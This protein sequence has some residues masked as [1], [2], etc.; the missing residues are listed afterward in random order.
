MVN[1]LIQKDGNFVV[2]PQHVEITFEKVKF[3]P[4]S[5]LLE[6]E[7]VVVGDA[8]ANID[9]ERVLGDLVGKKEDII[10]DYLQ[11]DPEIETAR[12]IFS[13]F[14]ISTLPEDVTRIDFQIAF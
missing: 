5:G 14:W 3:N 2:L 13:P 8:Y 1:N 12:V 6:F 4:I 11:N 9:S 10:K 7:A